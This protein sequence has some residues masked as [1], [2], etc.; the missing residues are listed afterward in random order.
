[1]SLDVSVVKY[2]ADVTRNISNKK[3]ARQAL[4][5]RPIFITH[6]YHYFI[7]DKIMRWYQIEH[8]KQINIDNNSQYFKNVSINIIIVHMYIIPSIN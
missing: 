6:T 3:Q 1:M 2:V 8:R 4:Q 5:K 7:I